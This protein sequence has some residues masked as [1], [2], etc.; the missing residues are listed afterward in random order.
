M[1]IAGDMNPFRYAGEYTDAETGYQYLRARYYDANVGR[2]LTEDPIGNGSNWYIYCDNNPISLV[3]PSG[4]ENIVVAGGAY[5]EDNGSYQYEFVD[6]ALLQIS[7]MSGGATL[8]VANAGWSDTQYNAIVKAATDRSINLLWFSTVD[9]LT[10]Y[11]N[12]G[13]D[14]AKDP[15][16]SF[17]LF[18]HGTDS[19]TNKYA[20]TFG[21]HTNL[22]ERF[23]WYKSDL[24]K[25]K[26]SAFSNN[27]T[28][29]FYSCRTGNT[30]DSGSFAQLWADVTGGV[31]LA[32]KGSFNDV[33]RSNYANII[34]TKLERHGAGSASY[35]SWRTKRGK[36]YERPGEAWRL[37]EASYLTSMATFNPTFY[38]STSR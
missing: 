23:R 32:Y 35:N 28:S 21:L 4:L 11:I 6:S 25:I 26:S 3:D 9:S 14:R 29:V 34:G 5:Y 16:T 27:M 22:D 1:P 8:L 30:F 20:I 7:N 38:R 13:R 15:I 17:Y 24:A 31:T 19:G 33:G 18:A 10:N 36:V 37:P 2:F 12:K